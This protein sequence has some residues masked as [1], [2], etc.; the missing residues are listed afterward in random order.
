MLGMPRIPRRFVY[1][2]R[3][4]RAAATGK[5]RPTTFGEMVRFALSPSFRARGRRHIARI[6]DDGSDLV[7][8]FRG[9][10]RPLVWPRG[11]PMDALYMIAGE[12]FDADDWHQYEVAETRV[13]PDDIVVDCGSAEGLFALRVAERCKRVYAV[14]PSPMFVAAMKRS[15]EGLGNVEIVECLLGERDGMSRLS[16]GDFMAK[17]SDSGI[18]TPIRTLDSLF[19]AG[20]EDPTYLKADVEGAEMRI[21][22]GATALL[23]RSTPRVAFTTYHDEG[24]AREIEALLKSIDARYQI[25][26]KGWSQFGTPLMIHAWVDAQGAR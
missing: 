12:Q 18:E 5:G 20:G 2:A 19:P 13:R 4:L 25:R 15:F 7:V 26:T 1:F 23:R 22:R 21:L 9:F 11:L 6:D 17:E 3:W 24:H 16:D 14:E 8:H 10:H